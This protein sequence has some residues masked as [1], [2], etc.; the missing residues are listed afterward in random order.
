ML[1]YPKL[2]FVIVWVATFA[3]SAYAQE[4]AVEQTSAKVE[5]ISGK[6]SGAHEFSI[7]GGYAFD[8]FKLWGK[9]PNATLGQIAFGYNRKMLRLGQQMLEY[10]MEI[11]IFSRIT[12]PEFEP[13]RERVSLSG[14]GFAPLGFRM[15]FRQEDTVQPFLGSTLG[16]MYLEGPFPDERGKK[17]NYT[18]RAGGGIEF[19]ILSRSSLSLG[20]TFFHLS[21]GD[22]G[23]VNPGIDSSFFFASLT[24]F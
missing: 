20:Y 6:N 12:Y 15:N 24:F 9:T 2:L 21:N 5:W 14:F 22:S 17:F 23:Q 13:G 3:G 18:L 11:S 7:L 10:R 16:F 8:S 19:L 1:D 4:A